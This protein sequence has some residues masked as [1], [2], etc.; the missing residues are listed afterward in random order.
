[1]KLAA[2]HRVRSSAIIIPAALIVVVVAVL[3]YRWSSQVVEATGVRLADTLQL[4]MINWHVDLFR[5]FSEIALTVRVDPEEVAAGG[6]AV[7]GRRF[8]EWQTIAR[9]PD[10][11]ARV[12]LL[13]SG[14]TASGVLR[15]NPASRQFEPDDWPPVLEALRPHMQP[16]ASKPWAPAAASRPLLPEQPPAE[17]FYSIGEALQGWWFE[18]SIPGLIHPIVRAPAALSPAKAEPVQWLVI[19]LSD[20]VIRSK[21]FPDLAHRYFMGTEGLDYDVAVVSGRPPRVIYSSDSNF[22]ADDV[23]DADG[24]LDLFGRALDDSHGAAIRVFREPSERAGPTTAAVISW[25]PLLHDT[26][27]ELDWRLLVRHRRGGPLGTFVADMR[28]RDLAMSFGAL[29]LLVV[30]IGMLVVGSHRAQR[31]AKLEM[32]FVTA[33]THELRTPLTVISSAA[34]NIAHGVVEGREQL[35]QYGSVI[36]NHARQLSGLVEQ[37]LLFAA[38]REGRQRY[39]LRSLEVGEVIDATLASTTG[40][41]Q[42]AQFTVERHIEP[43]LPPVT[44]DLLALSQCLQNL[45][46][47]ALKYGRAERWIG[48]R[49]RLEHD[50]TGN[51]EIQV[52]VADR[53]IGI[54]ADDLPHIFEPF[55]RSPSATAAQIHGTGLGLSL[56][57][58]IAEAM[59]GR[60][61]VSSTPGAGSVF[62]LHLPCGDP[63]AG[64]AD[65]APA[66]A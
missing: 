47:N 46:T 16:T 45:I 64:P 42:A 52:S 24:T 49:A 65:D 2:K 22:G 11:I 54:E 31:L 34:D 27:A 6:P 18:P 40:L 38:T 41:A 48:I 23:A 61:T 19:E 56:A 10:F 37:I 17:R 26:P 33:V 28:R 51:R 20:A 66:S 15:L 58:W 35:S 5:N 4:S 63:L 55:Y 53:G 62:T 9:Y 44:G 1:M 14:D 12:Y 57:K 29:V 7:Y 21:M 13:T 25:F 30:S 59:G 36:A 50:A 43:N 60:L 32:D 39:H 3:Q 8:A